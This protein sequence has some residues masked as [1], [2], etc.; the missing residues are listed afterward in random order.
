M[1]AR[2][3]GQLLAPQY[4][5]TVEVP[6]GDPQRV[7]GVAE[8]AFCVPD[9]GQLDHARFEGGDGAG[10]AAFQGDLHEGLESHAD[11][12]RV[13]EGVVAGDDAAAFEFAQPPGSW[14]ATRA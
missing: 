2:Q 4:R 12:G 6:R 11:G 8:E 7:V 10:V 13:H 14:P 5:E 1:Y 9:L 3:R